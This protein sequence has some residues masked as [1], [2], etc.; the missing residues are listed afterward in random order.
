MIKHLIAAAALLI[1]LLATGCSGTKNLSQAR[2]DMPGSFVEGFDTGLEQDTLSIADLK[3]WE[4]YAD[5][6]LASI[7]RIALDNNRD[8]LKAAAKVE[9]MRALYGVSFH[10]KNAGKA[11]FMAS[12]EDYR[13][14]RMT[15]IAEVATAYFKLL[16]L[17]SELAIVRQTLQTREE[18]LN[19]ARIRFE[20]GVTSET[21]YQQAVVEYSSTASLIPGLELRVTAMR[22]SLTTLMGQYPRD[23]VENRDYVFFTDIT[24]HLPAG[25]PSD[26]LKRRPDLRAAERRL[27]AAMADVGMTYADRFPSL[28]I[29]FTPG[30]E[31][32]GLANFFKSPFTYTVGRIA[33]SIFDFGRKKRKYEA[34]IAVYDQTRYDYEKAVIGA[35]TEVNTSI[36]A[37][38]RY[39]ENFYVKSDLRDAA[40]KYV[41][42]AWL[43][44]RGGTLNYIDVLDAQRRY[45]DAQIGV[46][47][48]L[49]DEYLALIN[50]Y[51]ALG[52]GW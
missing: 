50:L 31:N 47:N 3:W 13:A 30:F 17:E 39:R 41:Q 4:F 44:Y 52:G 21:V 27:Q 8:L 14:M 7:M 2:T 12:V 49:R 43:Q 35:F 48:A 10:A 9:Q 40:A 18:A 38:N 32:D 46:N 24:S 29:G 37:Y 51:K 26:L 11:R 45:F 33:G 34:A 15:L 20:G 1:A 19:Q 36:I 23:E 6:T 42:L 22:N 28:T 5:S 16:S 25:I